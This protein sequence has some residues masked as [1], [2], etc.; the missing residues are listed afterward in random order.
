MVGQGA[1]KG[2]WGRGV[3]AILGAPPGGRGEGL[4]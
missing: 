4:G 1:R 2:S 3:L